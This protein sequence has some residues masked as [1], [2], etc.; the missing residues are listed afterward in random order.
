MPPSPGHR[1]ASQ[2]LAGLLLGLLTALLLLT[3]ALPLLNPVSWLGRAAP[4]ILGPADQP[5]ATLNRYSLL[6][7]SDNRGFY[8]VVRSQ[9]QLL[10][11]LQEGTRCG[12][13]CSTTKGCAS[14]S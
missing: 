5:I 7:K 9:W 11:P 3:L 1:P 4:L 14:I 13:S 6:Y 8:L 12:W 2:P 10:K